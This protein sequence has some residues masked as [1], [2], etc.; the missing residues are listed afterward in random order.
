MQKTF[1]TAAACR[2][3]IVSNYSVNSSQFYGVIP[4]EQK[5][6]SGMQYALPWHFP[7]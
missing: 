1:A 5:G 2:N 3:F 6:L 7:E 4:G